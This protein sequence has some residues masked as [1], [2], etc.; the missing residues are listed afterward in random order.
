MSHARVAEARTPTSPRTITPRLE[1]G[2]RVSD[3]ATDP[4]DEIGR[5]VAPVGERLAEPLAERRRERIDLPRGGRP[6]AR[7]APLLP[8]D[9]HVSAAH[10]VIRARRT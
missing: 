5:I 10:T 6:R 1:I 4:C 3:L 7:V 2:L 8:L 9:S